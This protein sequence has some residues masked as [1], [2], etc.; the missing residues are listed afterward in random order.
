MFNYEYFFMFLL[1]CLYV[2]A[3]GLG[4]MEK[5]TL[6]LMSEYYCGISQRHLRTFQGHHFLWWV[7]FLLLIIK[8]YRFEAKNEKS[9]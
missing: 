7:F 6:L 3:V 8:N 4:D 2:V 1:V 5:L 9:P